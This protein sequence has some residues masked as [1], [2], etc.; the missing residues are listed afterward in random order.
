MRSTSRERDTTN[1]AAALSDYPL[2]VL[3]LSSP[4]HS[5]PFVFL[6]IVSLIMSLTP[7]AGR[8][9]ASAIPTPGKSSIP[10]PGR[11][12]SF[13]IAASHNQQNAAAPNLTDQDFIQKAF[14]DAIKANDPAAHRSA[15]VSDVTVPSLSPSSSISTSMSTHHSAQSR[16][17]S[18]VS[19]ASAISP[20]PPRTPASRSKP[21]YSR[22]P[23]RVSDTFV[24]S[25][26][27]AGRTF[28]IGDDVRIE[29]LGFEGTLRYL[30]EIQ[31][32]PGE[33]AGVELSGGFAGRG[34]ND[35]SVNG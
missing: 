13:S 7:S 1:L 15:R 3:I 32:K 19:S 24:R 14:A 30:G 22:P 8:G 20:I 12:R 28:E 27:R 18:V 4:S 25:S 31:G 9:R 5:I 16:P 26:S 29:S 34:K 33:W 21:S 2:H 17:P 35:G 23:S 10:T 6:F 11:L